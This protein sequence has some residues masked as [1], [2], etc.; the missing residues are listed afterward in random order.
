VYPKAR[1]S[2]TAPKTKEITDCGN[3]VAKSFCSICPGA[4]F[5]TKDGRLDTIIFQ[6]ECKTAIKNL[7]DL[8]TEQLKIMERYPN[9]FDVVLI[10]DDTP[11]WAKE[12]RFY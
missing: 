6:N 4:I 5:E 9:L 7:P 8:L 1:T 3:C 11:N 10:E 2:A 12:L